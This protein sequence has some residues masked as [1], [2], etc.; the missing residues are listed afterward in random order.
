M[1]KNLEEPTT[2]L[3]GKNGEQAILKGVSVRGSLN[4]T[5]ARVQVEQRYWNSQKC[6]I[7][8]VY[9]FP[10]PSAPYYSTWKSRSPENNFAHKLLR[11]QWR[12]SGTR[13]LL[14]MATRQLWF[15]RRA[16]VCTS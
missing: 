6:S 5:L 13:K 15:K 9:T 2:L 16:M 11:R 1:S 3:K 8:A 7:E 10:F 4:G 12:S 14:P